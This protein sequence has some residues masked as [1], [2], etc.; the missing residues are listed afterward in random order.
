MY[1]IGEAVLGKGAEAA[2]INLLIG[3][4]DNLVGSAITQGILR[5]KTGDLPFPAPIRSNLISKPITFV[6]PKPNINNS[7]PQVKTYRAI[8]YAIGK[9]ISDAIEEKI[10]PS[11]MLDKWMILCSIY[12]DP[13]ADDGRKLYTFHSSAVKLALQRALISYPP[14]SKILY[15][16]NRARNPLLDFRHPQLWRPPY[17]QIALDN[18]AIESAINVIDKLPQSDGIILEAG[19]PLL[20]SCGLNA[21]RQ[22]RSI[23]KD[24]FLIADLKTLDACRLE[25]DKAMEAG[26]DGVV[27]SGLASLDQVEEFI[28]EAK[29]VG[30]N[31]IVDMMSVSAPAK[32]L[33]KLKFLP[34]VVILHRGI[35]Q[36]GTTRTRWDFVTDI[37]KNHP[38][39]LIAVAGGIT[40]H[41]VSTALQ[42]GVDIIIVGRYITQAR[43]VRRAV[44]EF[45][46]V[47]GEDIDLHRIHIE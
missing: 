28:F 7:P 18:P 27:V 13:K 22:L 17:L 29:R 31:S 35:D 41:D 23:V 19:T 37:K 47:L 43:D 25:V 46:Q 8:E 26:A 32:L 5:S 16:K 38:H 42:S 2:H 14:L 34:H 15:E 11:S 10:I 20:K 6:I 3:D 30:I 33:R 12:L 45:T 9:A 44:L 4:R 36:E 1:L 21:I 39:L 40:P 24:Q